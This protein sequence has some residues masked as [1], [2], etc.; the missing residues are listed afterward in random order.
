[1]NIRLDKRYH[2]RPIKFLRKNSHAR[3]GIGL[4]RT[5][6]GGICS[7]LGVLTRSF[8]EFP[9]AEVFGAVLPRPKI[10]RGDGS[11]MTGLSDLS[12][13]ENRA[14]LLASALSLVLDPRLRRSCRFEGILYSYGGDVNV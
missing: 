9:E 5:L 3:T 1:M 7:G 4:W 14:G 12:T 6:V 13:A 10:N 2:G 8:P 11:T